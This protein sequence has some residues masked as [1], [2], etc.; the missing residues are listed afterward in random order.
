MLA[1]ADDATGALETGAR[2]SQPGIGTRVF[3]TPETLPG[4]LPAVIDT[5]TRHLSSE[6]AYARV[7]RIAGEAAGAGISKV[8]KKTDS[9]LRGHIAA[10]F[11]ALLDAWP[12]RAL[13]YAPAYPEL[14]RAVRDGQLLVQGQ[15]LPETAFASDPLNPSRESSIAEVLRAARCEIVLVPEAAEVRRHLAPGRIVVCDGVTTADLVAAANAVRDLPCIMAGTGS[16]ASAWAA[17]RRNTSACPF[18]ARS[19]LIVNGSL[20]PASRA[21]IESSGVPVMNYEAVA[22]ESLPGQRWIAVTT[23]DIVGPNPAASL[24]RAVAC[25]IDRERP[26]CLV[27]FGGDTLIALLRELRVGSV[28]AYAEILPGVPVSRLHIPGGRTIL[29]VSKAGGFGPPEYLARIREI[30]EEE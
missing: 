2:I 12:D 30:L 15:P 21:Q 8:F 11:R 16:L 14:G 29:L 18:R 23:S 27:V 24:A 28:Q 13:V 22:M 4:T 7:R 3:F 25:L 10:E 17:S 1:L 19:G 9:T 26:E 6:E 5:E 20:H